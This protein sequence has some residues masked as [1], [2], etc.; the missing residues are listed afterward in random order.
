MGWGWVA[1]AVSLLGQSGGGFDHQGVDEGLGQVAAHLV[2]MGV[3]FLAEQLRRAAGGAGAFVPGAGLDRLVLL[4]EAERDE[5]SAE[6]E[7]SFCVL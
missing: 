3:V 2:L 7:G 6:Q 4:V 1:C 5:E